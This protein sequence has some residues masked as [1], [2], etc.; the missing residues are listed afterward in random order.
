MC[1]KN[2]GIVAHFYYP[3]LVDILFDQLELLADEADVFA[4]TSEKSADLVIKRAEK[5]K[6]NCFVIIT[7][8]KGRDVLPFIY[9]LNNFNLEDYNIV[10]KAHT[11]K[12]PHLKEDGSKWADLHLKYNIGNV[13]SF[14]WVSTAFDELKN[15]GMI[16]HESVS[17]F[18]DRDIGNNKNMMDY[19]KIFGVND[20][21]RNIWNFSAGTMFYVRGDALSYLKSLNIGSDIFE[22]EENQLDGTLAHIIE[23]LF[24]IFIK[25]AGYNILSADYPTTKIEDVKIAVRKIMK[26]RLTNYSTK[27]KRF[28]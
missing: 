9:T 27:R 17:M 15:V 16:F 18:S 20:F 6:Y 19:A 28:R 5:S 22:D 11:K 1:S 7:E 2:L 3:E 25:K 23:R 4:T 14:N 26:K 10:L 8:N 24:P 12:S 13:C 21:C